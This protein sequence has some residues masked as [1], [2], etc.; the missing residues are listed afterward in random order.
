MIFVNN[1]C[2]RSLFNVGCVKCR[3]F[4]VNY[5]FLRRT[6]WELKIWKWREQCL[7]YLIALAVLATLGPFGTFS[8]QFPD[9]LLYWSFA[10]AV[11]WCAII[12]SMTLVLRHPDLDDWPGAARAA[13]AV[14][15]ATAP[16]AWGVQAVEGW[17][18]PERDPIPIVHFA[19]NI[20]V[21]CGLIVT[22]MYFRISQ[23]IGKM[24]ETDRS[25]A[26][27]LD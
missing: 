6:V 2:I 14:A 22:A 7:A 15:I 11:G 5:T 10:L 26:P 4:F 17:L 9:R 13:L 16:I 12:A 20:I 21:V 1:Y 8:L 25:A 23:R 3:D 27:F 24:P 18:R 19:L